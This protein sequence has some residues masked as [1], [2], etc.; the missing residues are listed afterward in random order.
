MIPAFSVL[1]G[2]SD[3]RARIEERLQEENPKALFADGFD[4][5]LIG[6]ARRATQEPLV[7]YDREKCIRTLMDRDGMSREDAEEFFE[8]NVIGAWMGEGTPVFV[9]T[10]V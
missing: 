8:F 9:D 6:I 7:A 5:A 3:L 1:R 4:D 10:E 2:M